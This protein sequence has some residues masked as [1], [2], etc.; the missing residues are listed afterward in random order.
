MKSFYFNKVAGDTELDELHDI[1]EVSGKKELEQALW[2]RLMTNKGEWVFDTSFGV[3]WM[4]LFSNKASPREFRT[5]IRKA[6]YEEKRVKSV[7]DIDVEF[8]N[9][10]R[11]LTVY[12][13]VETTEGLITS[14]GEVEA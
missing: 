10:I 9:K 2:M 5:E 11:K 7:V 1:Q 8:D 3:S 12:F 13:E 6:I 4:E 14:S